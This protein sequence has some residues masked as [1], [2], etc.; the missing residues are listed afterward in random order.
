M[1]NNKKKLKAPKLRFPEFTDDWEKCELGEILKYEQ[2]TNYLVLSTDYDNSF[3]TPV[4]TAGQSFILGYT[5]EINNIKEASPE[6][7]VIIF[8]DFTTGSH[9]VDFSFKVKSSAIKLLDLKSR[10]KDFYFSYITLKNIKFIPKGHERHWISKFSGFKV[11]VPQIN[12]Q[13]KIGKFFKEID[14]LITLNQNKIS[15][16][17]DL[18]AGLLQKMFPRKGEIKPEIRFPGFTDAWE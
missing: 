17:K 2:P 14:Q 12:E 8:D 10:D 7:P 3:E 18:K 15:H 13:I 6:N 16:I 1:K 4:L 5:D 9:Y 11:Y